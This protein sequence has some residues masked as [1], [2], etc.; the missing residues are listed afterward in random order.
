VFAVLTIGSH[1][2]P[3]I[4][5]QPMSTEAEI[6]NP[7]PARIQGPVRWIGAAWWIEFMGLPF[8]TAESVG[9]AQ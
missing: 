6:S 5:G 1:S 9:S 2:A 3:T 7:N 4:G 8:V